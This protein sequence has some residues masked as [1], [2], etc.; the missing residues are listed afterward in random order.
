MTVDNLQKVK[1]GLYYQ[2]DME[3]LTL[4]S[5]L[6]SDMNMELAL[7]T[8]LSKN[9]SIIFNLNTKLADM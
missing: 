5:K 6:D 8:K 3:N 4:K 2:K 9:A 1:H 7:T